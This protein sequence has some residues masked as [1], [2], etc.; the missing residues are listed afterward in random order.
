MA[1]ITKREADLHQQVV[2]YLKYQYPNVL[3][4]TDFA[5]GIKMS[6]GQAVKHKALQ[7][8]RAWP[9]I[10][11]AQPAGQWYGLFI[12]LKKEGV[13]LEKKDGTPAT[14]HIS[15]QVEMMY[16]LIDLGYYCEICPGF[17]HA[18]AVIDSYMKK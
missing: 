9:D 3:F 16:S 13:K 2:N 15:E 11:I 4:R 14:P 5:A 6:I 7:K 17:D 10:F 1:R 8:C 12:E 18:K